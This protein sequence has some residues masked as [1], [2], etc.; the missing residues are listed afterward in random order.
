MEQDIAE[1]NYHHL[2]LAYGTLL[3][4]ESL[5]SLIGTD[6]FTSF[7]QELLN[8]KADIESLKMYPTIIKYLKT[9]KQNKEVISTKTNKF[10]PFH[11]YK[12]GFKKWKESTTTSP[13][14]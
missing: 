14:G 10:I 4:I 12:Q 13:S 6:S 1:R 5:L 2:N 3:T 11:E 9:L 7:Y 8:G